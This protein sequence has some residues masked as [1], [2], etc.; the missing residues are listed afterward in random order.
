MSVG[1]TIDGGTITHV[2][3]GFRNLNDVVEESTD[4]FRL[5]PGKYVFDGSLDIP[6]NLSIPEGTIIEITDG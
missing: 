3:G 1:I 4:K 5:T 2:Y 6:R